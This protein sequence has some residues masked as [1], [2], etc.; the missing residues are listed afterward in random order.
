[1]SLLP[2]RSALVAAPFVLCAI[3]LHAK[4]KPLPKLPTLDHALREGA[5]RAPLRWRF[6]GKS[7]EDL[8]AWQKKFR[9]KLSELLGPHAP[10]KK[11]QPRRIS[12]TV[13]VRYIR[14]EWLLEAEEVPTL[15]L[16]LLRPKIGKEG[17]PI[18]LALHGHG[19]FGHDSVVGIDDTEKHKETIANSNYDYGRQF[20]ERGFLVVAPCMLPFGRRL[21]AGYENSRT[22]PCAITYVRLALLGQTLMGS[23]LR[24]CQWALDFACAQPEADTKRIACVGLSYGGRMTM[25]TA[26]MDERIKIA[27]PSGALN[28]M[29]ERIRGHYSCGAQ[30][31]PGLLQYGDVPEIG[32]LIAPRLCIWETGSQDKLI[33]PGWKERAVERMQRAYSAS[34]K[35]EHL[36]IHKFEGGHRWDGAS[37]IPLIDKILKGK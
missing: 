33:V 17:A 37:A 12:R 31:I 4:D 5:T 22:D 36:Q 21:D 27:V 8:A 25:L 6:T 30:V 28:V 32:S 20:A 1:M 11:F 9:G 7:P 10:P 2:R 18:I 15:P 3:A 19:P 35:P 13:L 16:Y 23:N 29:Q 14:E 24:D 34:G 26:A